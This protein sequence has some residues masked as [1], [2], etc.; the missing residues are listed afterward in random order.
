MIRTNV[1]LKDERIV[2]IFNESHRPQFG[3]THK[4]FKAFF[5]NNQMFSF[6][7]TPIIEKNE[8]QTNLVNEPLCMII[9]S[10]LWMIKC[11][12]GS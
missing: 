11:T 9:T 8:E 3:K 10:A 7:G 5:T 1:S 6:T 12:K 2:F 4:D